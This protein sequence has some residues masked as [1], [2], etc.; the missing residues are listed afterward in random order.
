MNSVFEQNKRSTWK[1][2]WWDVL[3]NELSVTKSS[4]FK[5]R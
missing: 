3:R 5:E 4:W 1:E 2:E